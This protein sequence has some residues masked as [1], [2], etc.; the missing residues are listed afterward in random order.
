MIMSSKIQNLVKKYR[1]N[2]F[3]HAFLF[4][5]NDIK[6]C[7]NDVKNLIKIISCAGD[8]QDNCDKCNICYQIE[9]GTIPNIIEIYPE[10]NVIKKS[11]I[12]NLKNCFKSKPLFLK[13]NIYIVNEAEKLNASSANTMLKFLEEPEENIIGFFITNNKEAM[14]D[15]I[16]SRCQVITISYDVDN[17][18]S[19]LGLSEDE[20]TKYQELVIKYL[21][22][23][24]ESPA[25]GILINKKIINVNLK[26]RK[27]INIFFQ[28]IYY[29]LEQIINENESDILY[30]FLTKLDKK[31][32]VKI[33]KIIYNLLESITFNANIELL[34]DNFVIEMEELL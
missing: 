30:S 10:N 15:T 25:D 3:S 1:E 18:A 4:V 8:Y 9:H 20:Q 22:N 6:K 13:N 31:T 34:L 14:L 29:L 16:I 19:Y 32:L 11:Q 26:D 24:I 17:I 2:K 21:Q 33:Q 12:L 5:T 23:L 28:Y 7:N 27:E